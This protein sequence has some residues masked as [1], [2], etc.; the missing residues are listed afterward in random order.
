MDFREAAVAATPRS[1]TLRM[2][3]HY[4]DG[5]MNIFV[6]EVGEAQ[7]GATVVKPLGTLPTGTIEKATIERDGETLLTY[8][9]VVTFHQRDTFQMTVGLS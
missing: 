9:G 4:T 1:P 5:S 3:L 7:G 2:H 6:G 8:E